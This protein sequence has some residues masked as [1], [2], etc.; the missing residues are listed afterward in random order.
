MQ[1]FKFGGKGHWKP[2]SSSPPHPPQKSGQFQAY[3]KKETISCWL[4][5]SPLLC[6][7]TKD[8]LL[9][10]I[11]QRVEYNLFFLNCNIL[12]KPL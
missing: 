6:Q 9:K 8:Q 7:A 3:P 5:D 2:I 10:W 12:I 4:R 1:Q 11:S